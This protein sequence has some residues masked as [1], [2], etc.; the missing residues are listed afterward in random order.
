MNT[1]LMK[2]QGDDMIIHEYVMRVMM[3]TN[4]LYVNLI[5]MSYAIMLRLVN[6]ARTNVSFRRVAI[7][8]NL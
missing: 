6:N 2:S 4:N 1:E 8:M 7:T 3:R 5:L